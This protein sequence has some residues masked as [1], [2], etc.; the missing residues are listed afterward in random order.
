MYN[1]GNPNGPQQATHGTSVQMS[2]SQQMSMSQ[3][4]QQSAG[5]SS[6]QVRHCTA[7]QF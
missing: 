4:Q 5:N 1:S 7:L 6:M 2:Q 3:Q